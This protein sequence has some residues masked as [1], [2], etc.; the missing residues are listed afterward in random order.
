MITVTPDAT[1]RQLAAGLELRGNEPQYRKLINQWFDEF[2]PEICQRDEVVIA[3]I[4]CG[5]GSL[6]K[7][8]ARRLP[9]HLVK[10]GKAKIIGVDP[11]AT[12]LQVAAELVDQEPDAAELK[13]R[14]EWRVGTCEQPGVSNADA[15]IC[16]TVFSVGSSFR[17]L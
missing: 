8:L 13:K 4:G 6:V 9:E 3:E 11:S 5:S 17:Y 14:I 16:V 7:Q 15:V 1:V 2:V 12:L 10:A